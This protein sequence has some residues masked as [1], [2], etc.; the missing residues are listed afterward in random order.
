MTN[1]L[2]VLPDDLRPVLREFLATHSTLALATAGEQDGRPQVAP[3]FFA[4]DDDFNIYWVSSVDSRH[5]V[6]I[7]D[8]DDVAA[9][10]YEQTWEWTGIRGIQIEGAARAVTGDEER[11]HALE[12]YKTKFPFVNDRFEA[13][14]EQSNF[15]VLR[16]R[17]M[18]W[19]DNARHF[20]YKQEF[21][22]ENDPPD[23]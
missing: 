17:W 21:S 5:S 11:D 20:G 15:Y 19:L 14:I 16:P 6:N 18:R 23:N 22:F 3:L 4:S 8:W 2:P 1:N 9:A 13:L 10:V 12:V 7:A